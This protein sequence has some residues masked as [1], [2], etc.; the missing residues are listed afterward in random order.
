MRLSL[1]APRSTV[2]VLV[3]VLS[4]RLKAKQKTTT[5][6]KKK[7]KHQKKSTKKPPSGATILTFDF[8]ND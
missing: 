2:L 8:E 3:R 7:K 4:A 1:C 5:K 6:L